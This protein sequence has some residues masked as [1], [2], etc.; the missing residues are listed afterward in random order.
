MRWSTYARLEAK[1]DR[2]EEQLDYQCALAVAS[3]LKRAG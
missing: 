2:A 3:L 1:Y